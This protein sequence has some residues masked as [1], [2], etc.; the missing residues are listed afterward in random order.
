[1]D[2]EC[3]DLLGQACALADAWAGGALALLLGGSHA[4]GRGVWVTLEGR[5][6]CLSDVD[7]YAVVPRRATQRAAEARALRGRRDLR[8][9]RAGWGLAAPLEVAFLLPSDLER[10]PARPAT[11]ELARHGVV[12][13]G[14]PA[15]RSRLPRWEAR[16]VGVEEI[17]L[18]HENRAFE[19][20]AA[21]SGLAAGERLARF[22]ARHATLKS[23][24]DVVRV[25]A[26]S[27]G[28]YPEGAA[29][30][31]EWAVSA[32]RPALPAGARAG[33]AAALQAAQA[34]RAGEAQELEPTA[35][36][37]EWDAV[38]V[39]WAATWRGRSGPSYED[40]LRQARRARLRRRL[41]RA[42]S[43]PA[44]SGRGPALLPRL[45]HALRGTP[46]HRVNAAGVVLLLAAAEAA[47]RGVEPALPEGARTALAALGVVP[48]AGE[49]GW[50]V[51][52]REVVGA[53][54]RWVLDGQRT[55]EAP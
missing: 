49:R 30:L 51:L 10:L 31:V 37:R 7:L 41:R 43:W 47:G 48:G 13:R 45:R 14:D 39:A 27:G 2:P 4:T 33:F 40:A 28:E 35:A 22:Q 18:L 53:W 9:R 25:E 52:A 38:V 46:Q 32:A 20:L 11:L 17:L 36:R 8:A 12:L 54:D 34:W 15:W 50:S 44:R 16:D 55:A 42:V 5:R 24:L 1:V 26:L 29:A 19:L 21:W 6:W 3:A 23:A